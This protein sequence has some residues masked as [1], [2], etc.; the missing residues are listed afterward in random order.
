MKRVWALILIAILACMSLAGCSKTQTSKEEID[1]SK[2][3]I[4][5]S[6]SGEPEE[7]DPT[8]N[9][10]ARSSLVLQNLFRGLYKIDE[11]NKPVP[12]VAENHTID[13][14]G[15][16]YTFNLKDGLK[17]SDGK[18]LT[19]KDFEYSW[20]RVLNPDTGSAV[21][22]ELYYLKNGKAYNEGN[23]NA[24]DVG[25]KAIDEKTLQ[26]TL[27][28]PTAY[29]L[30]LLCTS[31]YCPVRKDIVEGNDSWKKSPDTYVC[32]GPYMFKEMKPKEKYVLVKNPNYID[33]DKVK[34]DV[35]EIVFIESPEAELAAYTN[36]EIDVSD[37]LSNEA[38]TKYMDTDEFYSEGRI[39]FYYLDINCE[40][41]PFNDPRVRKAF[42]MA[43]NRKQIVKNI[44]QSV[45]EPAFG[46][47]PYGIPHGVE[48]D[49]DFRDVIGDL[50]KEDYDEARKLLAEAGY[51]NGEGMPEITFITM[52]SQSNVDVAQALQS[53]WK[54]NLGV[55]VSIQTFESKVYWDEVHLG[56]FHIA[57]DGWTGDYPDPMTILEILVDTDTNVRWKGAGSDEFDRLLEENRKLSDQEKRME[58]FAKAE[59]LLGDEMPAIP[60]YF[61]QDQYLCKPHVKGVIKNYI[62]HTIFEYAYIE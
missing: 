26:V 57:R 49:K 33:A 48:T 3:K 17:W 50:Y 60:I 4:I 12:A 2:N 15:T 10:Y 27:E 9:I 55:E 11:N 46:F 41:E 61:Y 18:E 38:M 62:G 19:A 42:A 6:L 20:K 39:G 16:V 58:N 44:L 40:K 32:N 21:A 31:T 23:A 53:M 52:A 35:L 43:M 5:Y 54:E 30:D 28:Y 34:L 24:E 1:E 25:V 47:V 59:K 36:G 45:E 51:P 37:N 29:F 56:N 7:L 13:E 8:K 22:Y 14:T